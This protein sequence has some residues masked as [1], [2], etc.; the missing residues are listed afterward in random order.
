[1]AGGDAVVPRDGKWPL[2]NPNGTADE[3]EGA[4]VALRY[5]ERLVALH[6]FIKKTRTTPDEDLALARNRQKELEQ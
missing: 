5:R 4:R 1:L 3:T 6:G 2:G